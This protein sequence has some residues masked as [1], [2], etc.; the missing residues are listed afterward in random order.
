MI[1]IELEKITNP[2]LRE[3]RLRRLRN[4]EIITRFEGPTRLKVRNPIII[5]VADVVVGN[6][7]CRKAETQFSNR[8]L[9]DQFE[10]YKKS[11]EV[12]N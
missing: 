4:V 11:V 9:K 8:V 12:V 3:E 5:R 7:D 2:K 1:R 10:P 6:K